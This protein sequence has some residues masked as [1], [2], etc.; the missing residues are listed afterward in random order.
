MSEPHETNCSSCIFLVVAVVS[1]TLQLFSRYMCASR[2]RMCCNIS[3]QS[4]GGFKILYVFCVRVHQHVR[5][6]T[7]PWW[8]CRKRIFGTIVMER[9]VEKRIMVSVFI[10]KLRDV[11]RK[12]FF[13][14]VRDVCQTCVSA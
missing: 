5:G 13:L 6:V 9:G 2:V 1:T 11:V 14:V 4:Y 3:A 12:G 8:Q 7:D 10:R